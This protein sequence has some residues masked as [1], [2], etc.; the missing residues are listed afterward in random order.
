MEIKVGEPAACEADQ[1]TINSSGDREDSGFYKRRRAK[2]RKLKEEPK[3]KTNEVK[4]KSRTNEVQIAS[5]KKSGEVKKI[6]KDA[7]ISSP[8]TSLLLKT[9]S[10]HQHHKAG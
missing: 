2:A 8:K 9:Y 4:I 1:S 7:L 5:A 10:I 6:V 3:S